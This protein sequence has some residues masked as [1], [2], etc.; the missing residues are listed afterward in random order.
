M[1]Q[2]RR[3]A[4]TLVE[5]L[6]VVAIIGILIS[7]LLSAVQAAREA[8]RRAS[9][10]NNL[11]QIALA[12]HLYHD[13]NNLLPPAAEIPRG[14]VF[15]TNN[16]SWSI[17]GRILPYLDRANERRL[18]NLATAWDQPPNS[19]TGVPTTRIATFLCPSEANDIPRFNN[20]VPFVYP[21]NY[22]FNYGTWLVYDPATGQTGDGA[23]AV[24]GRL[25]MGSITDGAASTL[26]A[27]EV[28]TFTSYIRNTADLGPVPPSSPTF[29]GSLSGQVKLGPNL[30][31]NTGHT[32]WPDGRVHHAG[33]TT[34]F[35]PNTKVPYNFGGKLYD[36]DVNTRQEGSSLTQPTYAAITSRSYHPSVVNVALMDASVQTIYQ[37]IDPIV[38]RAIG[39][40]SG[41]ETQQPQF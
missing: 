6:V 38:W 41:G 33:F 25:T 2:I 36:I 27:A 31:D 35:P 12:V 32:E 26:M 8:G 20:G 18:V 39:T 5:L 3:F 13:A 19:T 21:H 7:L 40:R 24:N 30:N 22:G 10:K 28:K 15:T 9:C 23:F 4:F 1:T 14:A 29:A 17:H 37:S 11:H 34:V 16:G